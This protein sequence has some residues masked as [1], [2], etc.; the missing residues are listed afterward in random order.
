MRG[1]EGGSRTLRDSLAIPVAS[2]LP[3]TCS[4]IAVERSPD[5]LLGFQVTRPGASLQSFGYVEGIASL[6]ASQSVPHWSL[7]SRSVICGLVALTPRFVFAAL[8][9]A[10]LDPVGSRQRSC[11]VC[12]VT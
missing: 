9:S 10:P 6:T 12:S 11:Q 3:D 7:E 5:P 4:C 1:R 8:P 2:I